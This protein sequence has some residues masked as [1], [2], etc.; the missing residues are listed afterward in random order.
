SRELVG[1]RAQIAHRALEIRLL[2]REEAVAL[3]DLAELGRGERVHRL[4]RHEPA[5][6]SL[7]R[8]ERARLLLLLRLPVQ[9]DRRRIRQRLVLGETE[10]GAD[11]LLEQPQP[12]RG[13]RLLDGGLAPLATQPRPTRARRRPP[14]LLLPARSRRGAH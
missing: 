9:R 4:E 1:E 5:A 10:L 6:Q 11:L 14:L 8:G 3:A 13:A 12:T 2:C 7:Q